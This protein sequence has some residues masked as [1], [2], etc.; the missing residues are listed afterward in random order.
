M[1]NI[2]EDLLQAFDHAVSAY[3]A[4]KIAEAEQICHQII[5]N[6]HDFFDAVYLLAVV[7][8]S[9]G[10]HDLAL[11]S[12]DRALALEPSLAEA[13]CDRGNTL[14]ILKRFD[15]ALESYDRALALRP[16]YAEALSNRAN[17]LR[18]LKRFDEALKSCDRA[19]ALRP[20]LAETF[21]NRG[22][23]LH[24][25]RRHE[26][27]L[28]SYDRALSIR[29]KYP[30]ALYNRANALYELKRFTEALASI[31]RALTARPDY[32][33]ALSSRGNTLR[34]LKRLD[35]ALEC[36]DR[37]LAIRPD[38]LEALYDRGNTLHE[39]NR[40]DE[41]LEC[42]D[43]VLAAKAD[44]AQAFS[45][46]ASCALNLCDWDRQSRFAL[47]VSAHLSGKK[48]VISPFVLLGYSDDPALQLQCASTYIG[49]KISSLPQPFWTGQ[50]WCKDKLR[51][52]YVSADFRSHATAFLMAE[53]L[54]R[55]NRS[56]FEI[57]GISFG[58]D[59]NSEMRRRLVAA[60]DEFHDVRGKSDREIAKLL[61]DL[62]VDIAVDLKGYTHDSRPEIFA[63]RPAPIQV[64]Y[65]GYPGTMGT[66]FVDYIIADEV[67]VPFEHAPFYTERIV[68]LPDC[69]QVNDT[70][71]RIA[72]RT[73]TRRDA[74]LPEFGFVFCCFN[75]NWKITSVVFTVWMQLLHKVEG[76]ILWLIRD[77][78]GSE[79]SLRNEA[80]RRGV[81]PSRLVFAERLALDQH[82]ARHRVADLF[83][84][85]L[86][87]N[88][89][90]TAS[91][92]L[93]TGLPV[94]T[95]KGGA[96]AGRVAA[97]LLQAIGIPEL[98][99]SNF[100]DYQALALKVARDPGLLAGLKSK[101]AHNRNTYPLF[102]TDRFVRHI[103]SAYNTMWENL[104]RGGSPK[105]F[106]VEAMK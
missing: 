45:G 94:L 74:G 100:E 47:E 34:A 31:D 53:L 98:V 105:G 9:Q 32:A 77:N 102:N 96:F 66:K 18:E 40:F 3:E 39:M 44:Y 80:R 92:A 69:Y 58:I 91:D 19:L 90:T 85:T 64:S 46:A 87:Y 59:D 33:E 5:S 65:L 93:W 55:H 82:L 36:Y 71:R 99:T 88:A 70:T 35:E 7:Q 104:Q 28:A 75:N 101:L 95:C 16:D 103:E 2:S 68:H 49:R 23:T 57:I 26:E 86:P 61:F 60:F 81:D 37:A 21:S 41:A 27:A 54:E 29:P 63:F 42:Y 84:D 56:Q 6:K 52:A 24:E 8:S 17:S 51:I 25:L 62:Q 10:K 11:A 14:T 89:H 76:S 43:R 72:E 22:I 13:H 79:R 48:S 4:G 30:E 50:K 73:P 97:S 15:A 12:Y 1:T 106:S 83:L 20:D 78:D 38:L 67:V